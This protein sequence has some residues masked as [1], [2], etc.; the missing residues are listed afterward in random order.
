MEGLRSSVTSVLTRVTQRHI[1][2]DSILHKDLG[3]K[4]QSGVDS[5]YK[6]SLNCVTYDRIL[7]R[8]DGTATAARFAATIASCAS[9]TRRETK[10]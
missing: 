4:L 2:E 7:V 5:Q 1:P 3:R 9:F 6:A 10:I 8:A